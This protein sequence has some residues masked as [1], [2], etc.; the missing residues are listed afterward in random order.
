MI[1]FS[2]LLAAVII[3]R[4]VAVQKL[5]RKWKIFWSV[6]VLVMAFKFYLQKLL[7]GGAVF[8]APEIPPWILLTTTWFFALLM[9]F[10][11]WL[12]IYEVLQKTVLFIAG[13]KERPAGKFFTDPK[14]RLIG[15]IP[16]ALLVSWGMFEGLKNPEVHY[17]EIVCPNLPEDLEGFK[18]VH[19]SDLHADPLAG[20]EK[21]T[22]IVNVS[23]SLGGNL[24][25]ITGDF[26]DGKIEKRGESLAVLE[27]LHAPCGVFGVPGN[28]E[29][30]SGYDRWMEFLEA[31]GVTM[32]ENCRVMLKEN[33]A[34]CGVTD[35]AAQK[36][37]GNLPDMEKAL[38][39]IPG[40]TFVLLLA[41]QPKLA[42]EAAE[43][44]A[45]LQLSGHTHGGMIRGMDL[46]VGAFNNG[47]I[48]GEYQ[49][50]SMKLF[51]SNGTGIWNGFPLRLGRPPEIAVLTLRRK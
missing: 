47:F 15:L 35:P 22:H 9:F 28:H 21:M 45:D 27:K 11:V 10:F 23:N 42:M 19:L 50:G 7:F 39:G 13:K 49:L 25:V 16:A 18:I 51:I 36:R 17:Y 43:K 3:W 32:L 44:G 33:F 29:Y 14:W 37:G 5:A 30:Y 41:H 40:E 8:A 46:L 4:A 31:H 26:V 48:A 20:K 2:L 24:I 6:V 12:I 38:G 34:L 1:I